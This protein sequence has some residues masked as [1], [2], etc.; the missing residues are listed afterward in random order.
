MIIFLSV[1]AAVLLCACIFAWLKSVSLKNECID[2][3]SKIYRLEDESKQTIQHFDEETVRIQDAANAK[4]AEA[5]SKTNQR[6]AEL[7]KDREQQRQE[8][9]LEQQR[10]QKHAEQALHEAQAL[11][12]QQSTLLQTQGEALKKHYEDQA[13]KV[14]SESQQQIELLTK[15]YEPLR[16]FEGIHNAELEAQKLLSSAI[17]EA[18]ALQREAKSLLDQSKVAALQ[19]RTQASQRAKEIREQSDALLDRAT[20]D[21]GRIVEDA[22]K[23]A[24]QIGGEAYTALREKGNLEQAVKAI[25]NIINGYGDRYIIPTHSLLDDLAADYGHT[26]AGHS[27]SLAREQT[28]RMVEEQQAAECDYSE[29]YRRETAIRFV[30]DA[31]NGRVDAILSRSKY[32]NYGTLTQEI[33]DAFSLVNENGKA[34]RNARILPAYLDVRLAELKWAV[35]VNELKQKEREEQRRI[36]EQIREEERARREYERAIQEAEKEEAAIKKALE[37]ARLE[38]AAASAEQKAMFE[39]QIALLSQKLNDAEAKNQRAISMAQQTRKG[40]VYIISNVGS[41]GEGVFKIGMT[42]RLEP[43][44]RIK[45]L[46]DA[47][48]PFEFDVHAM[49]SSEDA[50]ALEGLLHTEFDDFRVNKVNFRKEF[51]RL[52]LERLRSFI[53]SKGLEIAFTMVAEAYE[54]RETQAINKMNPEEREKYYV[55]KYSGDTFEGD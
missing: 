18:E 23:R 47:S 40:N 39:E 38:E 12:D 6:I 43:M 25:Q 46:G 31:F 48:V 54:Y 21:A 5:N 22:H 24:E 41:F 34:F 17:I 29:T 55:T 8:F 10:L 42:R 30:I 51:F 13:Q 7:D 33:R 9:S 28:R 11:I 16:R 3:Q 1:L 20:R 36:K 45:E 44:D 2:L 32:D 27:L 35:V 37:K 50:P 4:V 14:I 26:D 19:E 52:P 49:I 53:S 15:T